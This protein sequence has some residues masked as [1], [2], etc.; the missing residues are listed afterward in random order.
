MQPPFKQPAALPSYAIATASA[1]LLFVLLSIVM[2]PPSVRG[3]GAVQ[4]ALAWLR[5]VFF[6]AGLAAFVLALL[7][8][9]RRDAGSHEALASAAAAAAARQPGD[10]FTLVALGGAP[11]DTRAIRDAPDAASAVEL[12]WQWAAAHPQEHVVIF[13]AGGEPIAFRRPTAA[14]AQQQGAA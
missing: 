2:Q 12:L 1:L 14:R 9:L 11:D 3:T 6:S 8:W 7:A 5:A 4:Q 10:R 13:A